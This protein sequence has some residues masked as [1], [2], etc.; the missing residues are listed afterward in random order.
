[1]PVTLCRCWMSGK[2]T[3]VLTIDPAI[4]K[5]LG[6]VP[7]DVIGFRVVSVEGKRLLIGEKIP[8]HKI[9]SIAKM[10]AN[11]LPVSR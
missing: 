11:V 8:L 7:K 1:M 2:N 5:E 6:L 10:P 4:R 9:A 3:L